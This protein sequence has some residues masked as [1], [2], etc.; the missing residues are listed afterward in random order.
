MERRINILDGLRVIAI[1]MVLLYHYYSRYCIEGYIEYRQIDKSLFHYG[2]LGVQ[3]FF[4][5]SGFVITLT[6]DKS[7]GFFDF[8]KRR[9]IR[10]APAMALCSLLTFLFMTLFDDQ[11]LF[12]KSQKISNLIFSNSF[13]SPDFIQ[14]LLG[15]KFA[16]IDGAYW[17]LWVEINFYIIVAVLFYIN[18]K[19]LNQNFGILSIFLIIC[20]YVFIS[21][22]GENLISPIIGDLIY[23]FMRRWI[24]IFNISEYILWFFLGMQLLQLYKFKKI[25]NLVIF[26]ITFLIQTLLLGLQ[27]QTILFCFLSYFIFLIFIYKP[28]FLA[29]LGTP[30]ISRLGVAS[31]AVY[32][33]HE[34]VGVLTIVK[35]SAYFGNYNWIIGILMIIISFIFGLL[36]FKY[37]EAPASMKIKS[38]IL[39]SKKVD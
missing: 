14:A 23:D 17:S 19:K 2:Y 6:L 12:L 13:M 22:T 1:L 11:H 9:W 38:F 30:I 28:A 33:I 29:F 25:K 5:I 4:I 31:Y 18:R 3:F 27:W 32:L 35:L 24:V 26:T 15:W 20:H 10:L 39:K 8:M 36:S 7:A 21:K 34:N 37:F 16:Y